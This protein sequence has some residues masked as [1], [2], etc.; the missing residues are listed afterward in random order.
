MIKAFM[1]E[2]M[3]S[4]V[5]PAYNEEHGIGTVLDGLARVLDGTG[6]RYEIVIVD[7][8]SMDRTAQ[9]VAS[10]KVPA[11][12]VR[13]PENRGY[14]A[15]LR[16]GIRAS[17]GEWIL[18]TD[19]D[20]TY[21]AEAIP[22]LLAQAE[23][24]DM[25]VGART[26]AGAAIPLVRRP[27]KWFLTKLANYLTG[28]RIPDLNSGLRLMRREAL[29][30]LLPLTPDGFSFTTTI[31]LAML[32]RQKE[33]R[34]VP[35]DYRVRVGSSKIRPVQDTLRFF[36]LIIRTVIYFNPLKVFAPASFLLLGLS[37]VVFVYSA[38]WMGRLL[39]TTVTILFVGGIQILAIGL[40]ADLIDKR[41]R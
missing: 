2:E 9:A 20:G 25:V 38:V 23:G 1:P 40:L 37:A 5:V 21:P 27:A 16:S 3:L 15:S 11:R 41:G 26:K 30:P 24:V 36:Q 29:T 17:R 33:V 10:A 8:G 4:V 7:D 12:V 6:R 34:F 35:I 14:G 19:A 18:I 28:R 13:H 22:G 32:T 39:D 31:T